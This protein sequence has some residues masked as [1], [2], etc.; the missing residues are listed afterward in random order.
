MGKMY[1]TTI[2][3]SKATTPFIAD[4][5]K[6]RSLQDEP[7]LNNARGL[8]GCVATRSANAVMTVGEQ[9]W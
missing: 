5:A 9:P 2:S 7:R 6:R 3:D 8:P 4:A 1:F